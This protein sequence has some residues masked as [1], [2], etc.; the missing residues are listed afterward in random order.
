MKKVAIAVFVFAILAPSVEAKLITPWTNPV[1]MNDGG[2]T[3]GDAW[4]WF[5]RMFQPSLV[6]FNEG[7]W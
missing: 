2:M 4:A 7:Y 3:I 5:K 6:I 1:I